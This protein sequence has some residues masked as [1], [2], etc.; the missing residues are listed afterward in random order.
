MVERVIELLQ[1]TG[2][3]TVLD[4][5][6]GLGN[7]SLPIARFAGFVTGVEGDHELVVSAR[8]NAVDNGITNVDFYTADL[9]ADICTQD[10]INKKHDL[11]VLDPPRSGAIEIL[12][13]IAALEPRKIVYV[14]CHPATLARDARELVH[15]FGYELLKAGVMDMFP[16]TA[17]VESIALFQ[18]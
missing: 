14:S 4:L 7:L 18:R 10:W 1:L 11:I 3:E 13:E 9:T 15:R 12:S 5:Y 16:H 8:C 17:H 2:N 6:C